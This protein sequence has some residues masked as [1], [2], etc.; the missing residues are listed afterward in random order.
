[1]NLVLQRGPVTWVA[2]GCAR[3]LV[4][5]VEKP[6]AL[7]ALATGDITPAIVT[8]WARLSLVD[9]R[10]FKRRRDLEVSSQRI[11]QFLPLSVER[12]DPLGDVVEQGTQS[13]PQR[14]PDDPTCES[15]RLVVLLT[16]RAPVARPGPRRCQTEHRSG[17]CD[18]QWQPVVDEA[19][20][21][22]I[23]EHRGD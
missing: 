21:V 19:V 3:L 10:A 15:R 16:A 2:T 20:A 14:L 6:L 22:G 5:L 1:S 17:H 11:L 23:Q 9:R 4:L 7:D 8:R 13:H 12:G 18:G